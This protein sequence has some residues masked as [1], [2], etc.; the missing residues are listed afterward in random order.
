MQ[1]YEWMDT[2]RVI[3]TFAVIYLHVAA[4]ILYLYGKIPLW[5][6]QIGNLYDSLVRFCV[7]V[8]F[9]LSGALLLN[10]DY[11][12]TDF[13]KKR[14][15]RVI[16]PFLFWSV[17]YYFFHH[18][19]PLKHE[20]SKLLSVNF[21]DLLNGLIHKIFRGVD[22]H[23]WF[24]YALLGLYLCIP[25]LRRWIK[26]APEKEIK[27]FLIVWG[28][29]LLY[30]IPGLWHHLP[31]IHLN[32][33]AGYIG[34]LV[35]GYYLFHLK[36]VSKKI[37]LT[38]FMVGVAVTFIGTYLWTKS[39]S[40]FHGYFYEYLSYNVLLSSIGVFLLFKEVKITH[41]LLKKLIRF[42]GTHSY[43]IYLVH[44][45]ILHILKYFGWDWKL[46]HP[47]VGVPLISLFTFSLS[48]ILIASLKK[49]RFLEKLVG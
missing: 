26:N 8:F 19:N 36:P 11:E 40:K 16:P 1:K 48:A 15:W 24:V 14:F 31:G 4:D 28:I 6:W 29:V 49:I 13:L 46:I 12:L 43:G 21:L 17:V 27:Y 10:R 25:I 47:V 34:Y 20:T 2:L 35:L 30:K 32:H 33:I 18:Y 5:T 9:M 7:P 42:I 44:V 45:L 39:I 41:L 3:A 38:F 23:V 22:Y 37:S